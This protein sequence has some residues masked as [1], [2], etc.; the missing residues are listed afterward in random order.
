MNASNVAG[1]GGS[2]NDKKFTKY[3]NKGGRGGGQSGHGGK[4]GGL[5]GRGSDRA[6]DKEKDRFRQNP[7]SGESHEKTINGKQYSWCGARWC[8]HST[9][10]HRTMLLATKD[11]SKGDT[12]NDNDDGSAHSAKLATSSPPSISSLIGHARDF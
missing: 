8:D 5:G 11:K 7:K 6:T 3:G 1:G 2:N 10:Q 12:N 4:G 9:E